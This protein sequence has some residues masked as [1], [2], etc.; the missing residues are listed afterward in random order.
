MG[1][2]DFSGEDSSQQTGA[3]SFRDRCARGISGIFGLI[4]NVDTE[5][6]VIDLQETICPPIATISLEERDEQYFRFGE[7]SWT[8]RGNHEELI[9]HIRTS[10]PGAKRIRLRNRGQKKSF[11]QIVLIFGEISSQELTILSE[12]LKELYL[13]SRALLNDIREIYLLH[14][15]GR[16]CEEGRIKGD[17]IRAYTPDETGRMVIARAVC[18]RVQDVRALFEESMKVRNRFLLQKRQSGNY[19]WD[20]PEDL[21]L[22]HR[23]IS[24]Y[25]QESQ[26]TPYGSIGERHIIER[27]T[28]VARGVYVDMSDEV[29]ITTSTASRDFKDSY[30]RLMERFDARRAKGG[31]FSDFEKLKEVFALMKETFQ[32]EE[33]LEAIRKLLDAYRVPSYGEISLDRFIRAGIGSSAHKA[34]FTALL[35]EELMKNGELNARSMFSVERNWRRAEPHSWV[36]YI[37]ADGGVVILDPELQQLAMLGDTDPLQWIYHRP[38][39]QPDNVRVQPL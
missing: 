24:G 22:R 2:S 18:T 33:S 26:G 37:S 27:D 12:T 3:R 34:L 10:C 9:K 16:F 6:E 19:C 17:L 7:I 8:A 15:P 13:T 5:E 28:P 31:L 30:D 20:S 11:D 32:G 4:Q 36:R 21:E 38:F 35:I 14:E 29:L 23:K 25:V 39:E 1:I